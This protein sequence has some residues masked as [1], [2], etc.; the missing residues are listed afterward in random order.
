MRIICECWNE[1]AEEEVVPTNDYDSLTYADFDPTTAFWLNCGVGV[2]HH[3]VHQKPG[4]PS[5]D[6]SLYGLARRKASQLV[7]PC[8]TRRE[9]HLQTWYIG[10]RSEYD[11]SLRH[12]LSQFLQGS[13]PHGAG[14][15]RNT[16]Q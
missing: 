12:N 8:T 3:A 16:Q 2:H 4:G 10:C 1:L 6:S 11:F 9:I 7:R 15:M 14:V 13:S 5:G